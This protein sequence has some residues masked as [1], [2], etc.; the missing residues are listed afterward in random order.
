MLVIPLPRTGTAFEP[1]L[2][3]LF[4]MQVTTNNRITDK[5]PLMHEPAPRHITDSR[6]NAGRF[7]F[8]RFFVDFTD[9]ATRTEIHNTC[10]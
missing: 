7:H 5:W 2:A 8:Y 6:L 9:F 3:G 10:T 4:S 1:G